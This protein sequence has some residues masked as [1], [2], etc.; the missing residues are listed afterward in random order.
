M[1]V[2]KKEIQYDEE[3][4][5]RGLFCPEPLFEVRTFS[6]TLDIGQTFKVLA[7]DPAAEEDLTRWAKRTGTELLEI[8][9]NEDDLI[10]YFKKNK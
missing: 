9:K 5:T 10:F 1:A 6:E 7:D 4:D 3:L 8:V 2:E